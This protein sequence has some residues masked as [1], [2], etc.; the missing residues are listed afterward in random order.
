M[1]DTLACPVR[2][3]AMPQQPGAGLSTN[4]VLLPILNISRSSGNNPC[5]IVTLHATEAPKQAQNLPPYRHRRYPRPSSRVQF[6][7]RSVRPANP[8]ITLSSSRRTPASGPLLTGSIARAISQSPPQCKDVRKVQKL[9]ATT[10][11]HLPT[12]GLP[13]RPPALPRT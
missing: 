7:A 6:L 9:P 3:M 1:R 2:D 8:A 4:R 12:R 10:I 13:F 5:L 11:R